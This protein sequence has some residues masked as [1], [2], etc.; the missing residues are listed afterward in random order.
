MPINLIFSIKIKM[1]EINTR[2]IKVGKDISKIKIAAEIIRN[3]GLVAF[4]TETVYGLGANALD[5][6]AVKK[7]FEAK[8]RPID[9]PIIV[10]I[11]RK[12]DVYKLTKNAPKITKKL[13][14]KFWPGPLTLVLKRSEIVPKITC[15][16]LDTIA[17]RM[18]RNR[19]ALAL[20][21]M[22]KLPIAA[23]SAN[24]SGKPSPTSAKHVINDLKGRIDV[25]IDGGRTEIG[26]E[27]T[28]LDLTTKIPTIL[29]PGGVTFEELKKVLKNV[30]I[31]ES[32]K[33]R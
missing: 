21:K 26:V 25:V 7:I 2:I 33:R 30:R 19:I 32:I 11:A 9:N 13:I 14:D 17:I 24:L 29:R 16:G 4:P 6:N 15:G 5:E 31:H 20:I 27:S 23:P 28:V 12:S 3:G 1:N 10:H 18:P 8:K 22:S